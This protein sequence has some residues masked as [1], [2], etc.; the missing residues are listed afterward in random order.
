MLLLMRLWRG[1][2]VHSHS[3][4]PWNAR[5]LDIRITSVAM[6]TLYDTY[7]HGTELP[8]TCWTVLLL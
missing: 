8:N 1:I 6:R 5:S 2:R 4:S 7:A 3:L